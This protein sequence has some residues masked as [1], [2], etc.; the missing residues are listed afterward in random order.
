MNE[1]DQSLH[2]IRAEENVSNCERGN[3]TTELDQAKEIIRGYWE[4]KAMKSGSAEYATVWLD[5]LEE[6]MDEHIKV[7][8]YI[9]KKAMEQLDERH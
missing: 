1:L 9:F 3:V 2:D 5:L 8:Y 6:Q 4:T 7:V